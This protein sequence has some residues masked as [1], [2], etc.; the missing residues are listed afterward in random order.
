MRSALT[1]PVPESVS[2]ALTHLMVHVQPAVH[3]AHQ[4]HSATAKR[5]STIY[6]RV[7]HFSFYSCGSAMV[8]PFSASTYPCLCDDL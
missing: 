7:L 5:L 4:V 1:P 2:K 8:L 3:P 6:R